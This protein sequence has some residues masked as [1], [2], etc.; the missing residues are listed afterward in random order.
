MNSIIMLQCRGVT[1]TV[2]VAITEM[3]AIRSGNYTIHISKY[4]ELLFYFYSVDTRESF[5]CRFKI[6]DYTCEGL[7]KYKLNVNSTYTTN[8]VQTTS[9]LNKFI[10]NAGASYLI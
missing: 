8:G 6:G 5:H 2:K 3:A 10:K 9:L 4:L 7:Y 1:L